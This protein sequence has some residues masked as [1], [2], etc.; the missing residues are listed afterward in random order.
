MDYMVILK[1]IIFIVAA[2]IEALYVHQNWKLLGFMV[3]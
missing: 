3:N 2:S 1:H